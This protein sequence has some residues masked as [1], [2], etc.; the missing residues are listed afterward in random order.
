MY[1]LIHHKRSIWTQKSRF[2]ALLSLF[3][4]L[5]AH[6]SLAQWTKK[7][8]TPIFA[9]FKNLSAEE[10]MRKI[11]F[12]KNQKSDK[13]VIRI[14]LKAETQAN[15]LNQLL[16]DAG[17]RGK[18][19]NIFR[20]IVE[21]K[22]NEVTMLKHVLTL[23]C[24]KFEAIKPNEIFE[25]MLRVGCQVTCCEVAPSKNYSMM[26]LENSMM[27]WENSILHL[28]GLPL[29]G[30]YPI[31]TF[32]QIRQRTNHISQPT[33]H[34]FQSNDTK[35]FVTGFDVANSILPIETT[36]E[37]VAKLFQPSTP[38]I[39][40]EPKQLLLAKKLYKLNTVN[41]NADLGFQYTLREILRKE[42]LIS[43]DSEGQ[44][45]P[46]FIIL[47]HGHPLAGLAELAKMTTTTNDGQKKYLFDI[48]IYL[49]SGAWNEK[50]NRLG[51]I[52][53]HAL[54]WGKSIRDTKSKY[55]NEK[56]H[57]AGGIAIG[58][59]GHRGDLQY[60]NL[61]QSNGKWGCGTANIDAEAMLGKPKDFVKMLKKRGFHKVVIITEHYVKDPNKVNYLD[62]ED[63]SNSRQPGAVTFDF[64]NRDL[65]EYMKMVKTFGVEVIVVS[66]EQRVNKVHGK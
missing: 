43:K 47:S 42:I 52:N 39:P 18:V 50:A 55:L 34:N 11:S 66:G 48:S 44:E 14:K 7:S 24:S 61:D 13:L 30:D 29:I 16:L 33:N 35:N 53:D 64:A 22:I 23:I 62:I 20:D 49:P 58:L 26:G 27:G 56:I 8:H 1:T 6:Q 54:I 60:S 12:F 57:S 9:E 17:V 45:Q 2:Q 46:N 3:L 19:D 15:E 10:K 40:F 25:E 63:L 59:N 4:F 37:E 41:L 28:P 51:A 5:W 31:F 65:Y 36:P 21:I 38:E 32:F